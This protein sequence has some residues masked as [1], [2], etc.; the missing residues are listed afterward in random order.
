MRLAGIIL[1]C[2]VLVAGAWTAQQFGVLQELAAIRPKGVTGI[3]SFGEWLFEVQSEVTTGFYRDVSGNAYHG[4][5]L[6][7][8]NTPLYTNTTGGSLVFRFGDYISLSNHVSAIGAMTQGTF[9]AWI[10]PA[11][12]TENKTLFS[13]SSAIDGSYRSY[14]FDILSSAGGFRAYHFNGTEWLDVRTSAGITND[15]WVHVAFSVGPLGNA[16]FINGYS[17]AVV[18]TKGSAS[19]NTFFAAQPSRKTV[20]IGRL[21]INAHPT[22]S[23]RYVGEMGEVVLYN[24][25][26]SET[27]LLQKVSSEKSIYGY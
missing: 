20:E 7:A 27:E 9:A 18:Y 26:L 11:A 21:Y 6:T 5:Q 8:T 25:P 17:Q 19:T 4:T 16:M 22:Y 15:V 24:H 14:R 2:S 1:L 23:F 12:R 10:K 13:V 3:P